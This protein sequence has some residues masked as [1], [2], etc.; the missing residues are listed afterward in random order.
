[1][2]GEA[3]TLHKAVD[4][5]FEQYPKK[6]LDL[7]RLLAKDWTLLSNVS[8]SLPLLIFILMLRIGQR[9]SYKPRTYH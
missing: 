7:D 4:R 6:E 1:M 2:L 8:S 9:F 3:I 5:F